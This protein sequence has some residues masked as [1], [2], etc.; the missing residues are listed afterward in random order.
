MMAFAAVSATLGACTS[1]D[2]LVGKQ[3]HRCLQAGPPPCLH[4]VC[5]LKAPLAVRL[6]SAS[7][8]FAS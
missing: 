3:V 7:T 8:S 1:N 2:S 5:A 4:A 6:C